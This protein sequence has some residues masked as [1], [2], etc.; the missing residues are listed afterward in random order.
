MASSTPAGAR[1]RQ[2]VSLETKVAIVK[3]VEKGTKKTAV[4]AKYGIADT[5]VSVN[6]KNRDKV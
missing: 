2:A 4:A 6:W 5:T 3:E 1:K